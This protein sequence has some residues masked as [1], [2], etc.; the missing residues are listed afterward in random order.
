METLLEYGVVETPLDVIQMLTINGAELRGHDADMGTVE[1]GK[2]ADLIVV[3]GNPL[4]NVT[5]LGNIVHVFVGGEQLVTAGE[6]SD[7]YGW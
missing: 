2:Y 7:W 5:A 3:E 1:R 4:E 6:L